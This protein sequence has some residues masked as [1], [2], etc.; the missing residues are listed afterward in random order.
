MTWIALR[1]E[2]A[3]EFDAPSMWDALAVAL[4]MAGAREA[5]RGRARYAAGEIPNRPRTPE[6]KQKRNER[7]KAQRRARGLKKPGRRA[8]C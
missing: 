2:I 4:A 3:R 8:A 5:A 1:A 7:L 6:Q